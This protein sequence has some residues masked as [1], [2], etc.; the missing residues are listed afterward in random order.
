MY[1]Y[2]NSSPRQ[3][4]MRMIDKWSLQKSLFH[5]PDIVGLK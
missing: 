4:V 1:K 3:K 2:T 5:L